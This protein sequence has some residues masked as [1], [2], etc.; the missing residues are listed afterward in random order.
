[1]SQVKSKLMEQETV[2]KD[3][4]KVT[5]KTISLCCQTV[6]IENQN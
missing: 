2:F 3:V 5:D 6:K 1:M 4:T